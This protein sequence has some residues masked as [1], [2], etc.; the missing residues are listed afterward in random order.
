MLYHEKVTDELD[1]WFALGIWPE[2]IPT[3]YL[4]NEVREGLAQAAR[5]RIAVKL[6][7]DSVRERGLTRPTRYNQ[8]R[9]VV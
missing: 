8:K 1:V 9:M 6:A 7:R 3:W 4:S 2:H 5:D